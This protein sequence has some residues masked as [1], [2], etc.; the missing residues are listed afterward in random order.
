MG[1]YTCQYGVVHKMCR[2]PT[3]HYI[4][5]DKVEEHSK[6]VFVPQWGVPKPD[7]NGAGE[8]AELRVIKHYLDEGRV[9]LAAQRLQLMIIARETKHL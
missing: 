2:C 3:P 5:C 8:L 1:A 7:D 9:D 6:N 4:N